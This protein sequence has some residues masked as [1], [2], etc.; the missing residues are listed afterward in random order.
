[1]HVIT[2]F[3]ISITATSGKEAGAPNHTSETKRENNYVRLL[4]Y[5]SDKFAL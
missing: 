1:M 2:F 4:K 3:I 5:A